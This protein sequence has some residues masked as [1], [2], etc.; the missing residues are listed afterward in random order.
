MVD[1]SS[2]SLSESTKSEWDELK[3]DDLTH[4]E[5]AQELLDAYRRDN[6]EIVD[7]ESIVE[8]INHQTASKIE[9]AAFRGC[10]EAL[11]NHEP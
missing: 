7:V 2:V 11:E 6:G 9:L 8:Q 10:S 1:L 4:G 3:P 5:F